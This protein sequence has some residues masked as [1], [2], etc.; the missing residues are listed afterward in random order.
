ME[1]LFGT[2]AKFIQNENTVLLLTVLIVLASLGAFTESLAMNGN[3]EFTMQKYTGIFVQPKLASI[4]FFEIP[5]KGQGGDGIY[6]LITKKIYARWSE[7]KNL[8]E[9]TGINSSYFNMVLTKSVDTVKENH[10]YF[11]LNV[12]STFEINTLL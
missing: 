3:M 12:L 11:C 2:G 1:F 10:K 7:D 4:F 9:N 6:N 8:R 5:S